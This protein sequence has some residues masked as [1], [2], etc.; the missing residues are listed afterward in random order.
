[1]CNDLPRRYDIN[2]LNFENFQIL[3]EN[4]VNLLM[5]NESKFFFRY[6]FTK[7]RTIT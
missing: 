4:S 2:T 3:N 6:T 7:Q 1:M 5:K